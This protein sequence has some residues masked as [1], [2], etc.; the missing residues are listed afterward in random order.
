[1]VILSSK[2]PCSPGSSSSNSR[3][4]A[5]CTTARFLA[6]VWTQEYSLPRTQ[7]LDRHFLMPPADDPATSEFDNS[8]TW[9]S[10][11][12]P[13]LPCCTACGNSKDNLKSA[14]M[15]FA[16]RNTKRN[17]GKYSTPF[18]KHASTSREPGRGQQENVLGAASSRPRDKPRGETVEGN[19]EK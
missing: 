18:D 15:G 13:S 10:T 11:P 1:M 8:C 7:V 3:A 4:A 14:R 17:S 6:A 5:S 12:F 2:P 16:T 19:I 9:I